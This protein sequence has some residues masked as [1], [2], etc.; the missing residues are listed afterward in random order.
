MKLYNEVDCKGTVSATLSED[1][2][3]FSAKM[4]ATAVYDSESGAKAAAEV[5]ISEADRETI[6]DAM[7]KALNNCM[8][9][10]HDKMMDAIFVSRKVAKDAGEMK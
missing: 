2:Q 9:H 7:T 4:M 1:G 8:P 10:I 6:E 5:E 3:K